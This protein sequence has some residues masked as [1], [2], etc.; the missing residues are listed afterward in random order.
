RRARKPDF[1]ARSKAGS[2]VHVER[3]AVVK[4]DLPNRGKTEAIAFETGRE[5]RLKQPLERLL[6]H[7]PARIGDGHEHAVTWYELALPQGRGSS[8]FAR[9]DTDSDQAV[10]LHRLSRVVANIHDDLL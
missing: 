5:K 10:R 9:F 1:E 6:I 4:H 2:A 8:D 3:T 7:A